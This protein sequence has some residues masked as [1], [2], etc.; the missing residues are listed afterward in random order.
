MFE[1]KDRIAIVTGGGTGIGRGIAL[2]CAKAGANVVVASRN[3]ENLEKV[4]A[5]IRDLGRESLVVPTDICIP[6]QVDNM[7]Q[8]V[9]NELGPVDIL[10]NNAGI[11]R[12]SPVLET[13]EESWDS[14]IDVNLK[15]CFLCSQAVSKGM[16]ERE[17]GSIISISSINGLTAFPAPASYSASKAGIIMLTRSLARELGGNNIRVN[18]VAPGAMLTDWVSHI[19]DMP[20]Q[21]SPKKSSTSE[22]RVPLNRAGEPSEVASAVLFLASDAASY[23]TGHT[24]VVDG[25]WLA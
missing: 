3:R 5:E 21:T 1:L 22:G 10:V 4:A 7:V 12:I 6:E 13:D 16:V 23:I 25:G 18:A 17:S 8:R 24:L 14:V 9:N 15:G 11:I 2:E 19:G 20:V